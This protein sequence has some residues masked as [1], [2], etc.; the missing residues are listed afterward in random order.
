MRREMVQLNR[1]EKKKPSVICWVLFNFVTVKILHHMES[2]GTVQ[3]GGPDCINFRCLFRDIKWVETC[4]LA[5][6]LLGGLLNSGFFVS[7][8]SYSNLKP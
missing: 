8:V 6:I 7:S 4:P 5:C 3:E 1:A 2:A